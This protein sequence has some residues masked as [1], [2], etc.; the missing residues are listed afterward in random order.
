VSNGM[1][2]RHTMRPGLQ[3]SVVVLALVGPAC[4][5]F[6]GMVDPELAA[7]ERT[8]KLEIEQARRLH[9]NGST[10]FVFKLSNQGATVAEACLGP[11]RSV[12]Y[13]SSGRSGT[14]MTFVDHPGCVREFTLQPSGEMT[15]REELEVP[16][17]AHGIV[18]VEVDVEVVNPR[19]CGGC[20][21]STI[22]LHSNRYVIP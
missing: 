13:S 20:G 3:A 19:R 16:T 21:C 15:W 11:G 14:S 1:D 9:R 10:E 6:P 4:I 18:E 5:W 7:L 17:V 12:S 8:L 2:I 22:E